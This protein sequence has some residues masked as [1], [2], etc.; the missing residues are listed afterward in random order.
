LAGISAVLRRVRLGPSKGKVRTSYTDMLLKIIRR[1]GVTGE[2]ALSTTYLG[3]GP[4][5]SS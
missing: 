1:S 4:A 5:L 2:L 3:R